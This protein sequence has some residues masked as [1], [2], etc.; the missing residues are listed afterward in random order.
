MVNYQNSKIYKIVSPSNPDLIYY[1]STTQKLSSRM[2]SHRAHYKKNTYNLTSSKVLCFEDAI[3]LL[4]ENYP[5]N[6]KEE[7]LK[8][9]GECILNNDCINKQIAGRTNTIWRKD[10][11]E[12]ISDKGAEYY[13]NNKEQIIKKRTEYKKNNEEK[14]KEQR[15]KYRGQQKEYREKNKEKRKEYLKKYK[16]SLVIK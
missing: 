8:K 11:K 15:I 6:S 16:K 1:G 14:I 9:E 3:I 4:V 13:K 10:N 12:H 7:L 2:S 5:C